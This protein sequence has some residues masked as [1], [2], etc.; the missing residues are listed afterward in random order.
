MDKARGRPKCYENQA[1]KQKAYR[2]RKKA[3]VQP[4]RKS[5]AAYWA[6]KQAEYDALSYA[7]RLKFPKREEDYPEWSKEQQRIHTLWS[8]AQHKAYYLRCYENDW[9]ITAGVRYKMMPEIEQWLKEYD[10][11]NG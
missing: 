6:D 9:F 4:L 11:A 5:A 7:H 1:D 2:E 8:D 3:Q 10:H